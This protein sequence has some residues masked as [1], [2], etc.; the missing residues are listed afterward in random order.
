MKI[1]FVLKK[2]IRFIS[3]NKLS[4][5]RFA[6][7]GAASFG[8]SVPDVAFASYSGADLSLPYDRALTTMYEQLTGPIPMIGGTIAVA[9]GGAMYMLGEGQMTRT[10]M[11]ICIGSGI[12]M[13][14]PQVINVF[15]GSNAGD[16]GI[17][18]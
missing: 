8:V 15:A 2:T 7:M 17:L 6:V 18:F 5:L 12:A 3:A 11:R 4:C 14:S 13:L 9:S 1:G 10:A 16:S